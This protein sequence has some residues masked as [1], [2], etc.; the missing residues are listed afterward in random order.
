M[1]EKEAMDS[2]SQPTSDLRREAEQRLRGREGLSAHDMA[3]V[4]VRALLHKL[5]VHQI[6]LEMQNEELIR[7]RN[8]L[9]ETLASIADC[10][11]MLDREW[12]FTQINDRA[13]RYFALGRDD[14]LGRCYWEMF[15]SVAGTVS[16]EYFKTAVS[17]RIPVSFDAVSPVMARWAEVHGYPCEEGLSV[18]F[19]D[20]TERVAQHTTEVEQRAAHLRA[21]AVELTQAEQRERRR[22]AQVL[23]D[24]LQQLLVA[25]RM[26][27][28]LLHHRVQD[29]QLGQSFGELDDLLNETI[30]ESRSLAVQLY[31]PILYNCGL[32]AGLE[33]LARQTEAKFD[34]AVEVQADA[35]A[36]PADESTRLFLFQA[37]SELLLN[38]V[39]H[40]RARR[41][42][43]R[44]TRVGLLPGASET[45][46]PQGPEQ[47]C[48]EVCDVGV[49]LDPT[50]MAEKP[51]GGFGMF[52]IRQRLE[53]F[54]GHLGI[55]SSP[56]QGTQVT[57]RLPLGRA[58]S[59][60]VET[61]R[62]AGVKP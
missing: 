36:E 46:V 52:S 23:H 58:E 43:V 26:K 29:V 1:N 38:V 12:R 30:N 18:Y 44:M 39:K 17:E 51:S 25:A 10:H 61:G 49:G 7:A 54:G 42:E 22:L 41:V 11:Y 27:V 6:E 47:V 9:Q 50:Q 15:P 57:I 3:E 55:R 2:G 35:A 8:T 56:G 31:P 4:D 14:F 48:I 45:P 40:A 16:E 28:G 62:H 13:L 32:A 21:L 59:P 24:H 19:K 53:L 5:Q 37:A 20:I 34:Q 33:W 60:T